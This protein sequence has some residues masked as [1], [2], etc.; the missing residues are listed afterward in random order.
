MAKPHPDASFVHQPRKR[1]GQNFL[2]D[3]AVIDRIAEAIGRRDSGTF[4]EIGPGQGALTGKLLDLTPALH[5]IEIDRDLIAHLRKRFAE[6]RNFHVHERDALKLQLDTLADASPPYHVV[7]NL[8]YNISTPLLFHLF[9]QIDAVQDFHFMLQREVVERMVAQPATKTYSRLSIATQLRCDARMLFSVGP[10]AFKPAP[11]V[12][13]AV[14]RLTPHRP[15]PVA[16]H[17][18]PILN[19]LLRQ[20]FSQRRKKIGNALKHIAGEEALSR[21]EIRTDLRAEV[22]PAKQYARLAAYLNE[23]Q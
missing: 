22:I 15:Q 18:W 4:I 6:Q 5:A 2:H 21:C 9:E 17:D 8:P 10:G 7:G 12:H 3:P 11:K 1:F 23:Q 20:A 13:S 14:V 16:A 19:Q